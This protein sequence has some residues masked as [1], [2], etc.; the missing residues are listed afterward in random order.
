MSASVSSVWSST[1]LTTAGILVQPEVHHGAPAP[2]A[3]DQL[4][5]AVAGADDDGLQQARRLDRR[6]ELGERGFIDGGARL[7]GIGPNAVH[8]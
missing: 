7:E 4:V 2:L 6:G 3:G 8:R 5:A 1:S